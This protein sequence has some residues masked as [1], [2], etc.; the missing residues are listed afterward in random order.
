MKR[1]EDPSRNWKFS[2]ADVRERQRWDDY[3]DAFQEAIKATATKRA[4]W[5]VVPADHKWFSRLV[6]AAAIVEVVEKL[7]LTYPE[8]DPEK[9]SELAAARAE[10]DQES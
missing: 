4:P 9:K 2:S 3:Q 1:I 8:V 6:V 7:D 10:L 5:Y